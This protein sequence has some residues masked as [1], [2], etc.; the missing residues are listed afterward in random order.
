MDET[1]KISISVTALL[2]EESPKFCLAILIRQKILLLGWFHGDVF[3]F[4][5]KVLVIVS[6]PGKFMDSIWKCFCICLLGKVFFDIGKQASS[7]LSLQSLLLLCSRQAKEWE[8][9]FL[10]LLISSTSRKK[11]S[12]RICFVP[13]KCSCRIWNGI[14]VNRCSPL[15]EV[16]LKNVVLANRLKR[17]RLKIETLEDWPKKN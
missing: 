7:S 12:Q 10:F 9:V 2:I 16:T 11:L 8:T 17:S 15:L 5:K 4:S 13:L 6:S 3:H 14:C 1:K